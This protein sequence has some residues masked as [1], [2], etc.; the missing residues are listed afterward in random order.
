MQPD[1]IRIILRAGSEEHTCK[2]LPTGWHDYSSSWIFDHATF[3]FSL[4]YSTEQLRFIKEDADFI[5][6]QID[7]YGVSAEID[8]TVQRRQENWT[9]ADSFSGQVNLSTGYINDR[10]FIEV[11]VYEGGFKRAY[12]QFQ[13]TN[14]ELPLAAADTITVPEGMNI[15]EQAVFN[16]NKDFIGSAAVDDNGDPLFPFGEIAYVDPNITVNEEASN[17]STNDL[18]FTSSEYGRFFTGKQRTEGR[19]INAKGKLKITFSVWKIDH[20]KNFRIFLRSNQNNWEYDLFNAVLAPDLGFLDDNIIDVVIE[21]DFDI[22]LI[23]LSNMEF[24]YSLHFSYTPYPLDYVFYTQTKLKCV[25]NMTITYYGEVNTGSFTFRA[26][27]AEEV[28]DRLIK[29]IYPAATGQIPL[30]QPFE[31]AGMQLFVTSGDGIRGIHEAVVRTNFAEFFKNIACLF[32]AGTFISNLQNRYTIMDKKEVLNA[33]RQLLDLGAVK[34]IQLK[35][36]DDEWLC[37]TVNVGYERQEYDYPLGRQEFA[38]VLEYTNALKIANKKVDLVSSYRADY[39]GV[40]LLHFDYMNSDKTDSKSDNDIFWILALRRPNYNGWY[41]EAGGALLA[42]LEGGGYFNILLSPHRNLSRHRNYLKSILDKHEPL[43]TYRSST[44][45]Q[46]NITSVYNGEQIEEK[47]NEDLSSGELLFKPLVFVFECVV[48][49][50]LAEVLGENPNGYFT[51]HY[52]N[53]TLK[54]FPVEVAGSYKDSSQ[55]VKCVAH[56]DTPDNIQEI[57]HKKLPNKLYH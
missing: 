52:N 17:V 26:L 19:T 10:D 21:K 42:G 30:L 56:P 41:A 43:L 50:N 25:G 4:K 24:G 33:N 38:C 5:R 28:A 55:T 27:K 35:C 6:R 46:T 22:D 53:L 3:G 48:P 36:P 18:M 16:M 29:N 9:Y 15:Y 12:S 47:S 13:K 11:D 7:L 40:H 39:T 23:N 51:F 57:L 20:S 8:F 14:Y 32:D 54:G 37:N 34:N 31:D 2:Y 1:P 44:E 45:I 49:A